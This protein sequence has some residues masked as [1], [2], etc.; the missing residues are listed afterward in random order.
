[1]GHGATTDPRPHSASGHAERLS[2]GA[3][4]CF[5]PETKVAAASHPLPGGR[6]KVGLRPNWGIDNQGTLWFLISTTAKEVSIY[7][8]ND[9][10]RYRLYRRAL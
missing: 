7:E 1:M 5:E 3:L 8:H 10:S 2:D 9:I 6:I 4:G